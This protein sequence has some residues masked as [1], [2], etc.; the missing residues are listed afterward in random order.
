MVATVGD[1]RRQARPGLAKRGVALLGYCSQGKI[2]TPGMSQPHLTVSGC[3]ILDHGGGTGRCISFLP[4]SPTSAERALL[5]ASAVRSR[6][7]RAIRD[8]GKHRPGAGATEGRGNCPSCQKAARITPKIGSCRFTSGQP[9]LEFD[10]GIPPSE[11]KARTL[12]PGPPSVA[13]ISNYLSA[14][15]KA[16]PVPTTYLDR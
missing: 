1:A 5:S 2:S 7:A 6:C 16:Y 15:G 8:A 11:A 12:S 13:A 3:G 10:R 14:R 4:R 9:F